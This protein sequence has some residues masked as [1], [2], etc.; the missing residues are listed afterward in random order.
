MVIQIPYIFIVLNI[1]KKANTIVIVDGSPKK[2]KEPE[3]ELE[4][5]DLSHNDHEEVKQKDIQEIQKE[6]KQEDQ[7]ENPRQEMKSMRKSQHQ[8]KIEEEL[9][10]HKDSFE[11]DEDFIAMT[12][13]C[14]LKA[15]AEKYMINPKKQ[16]QMLNSCLLV[17]GV[18]FTM[19]GASL[20]AIITNEAEAYTPYMSHSHALWLVKLPCAVALHFALYP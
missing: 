10:I 4:I 13:L 9:L 8:I 15:N 14:Y 5:Q 12:V 11:Y 6:D 20:Y 1:R 17:N 2:E 7:Q 3:K 19:L 18:V 16:S